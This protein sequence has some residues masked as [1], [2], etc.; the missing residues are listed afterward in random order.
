MKA[1]TATQ[2]QPCA[3]HMYFGRKLVCMTNRDNIKCLFSSFLFFFFFFLAQCLFCYLQELLILFT[4]EQKSKSQ[5][6]Q[7]VMSFQWPISLKLR[8]KEQQT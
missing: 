3:G 6:K 1:T 8:A 4:A 7:L 5:S 2:L